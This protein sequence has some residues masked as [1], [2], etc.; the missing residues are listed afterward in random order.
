MKE[1]SLK[2]WNIR[3]DKMLTFL[4]RLFKKKSQVFLSS[5]LHLDHRNIIKYCNRPFKD[6][7]EMN[8]WLIKNWNRT[9]GKQDMVYFLGDLA[10]TRG[11]RQ[12]VIGFIRSLNGR[13]I[14]IRGNHD[15][16][17]KSYRHFILKYGDKSFYLVHNPAD[18]PSDWNGWSIC[19][20]T[21]QHSRFIDKNKK[22][23]NVSPEVTG[24]KPVNIK[25]LV[26]LIEE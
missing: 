25:E 26:R 16:F 17:L 19:G 15:R 22:I 3:T 20:H 4:K 21:H 7:H 9:V 10:L 23:I 1:E 18:I 6:V 12:R 8:Y 2:K 24:Y 11:N 5:D 13:K 14:F